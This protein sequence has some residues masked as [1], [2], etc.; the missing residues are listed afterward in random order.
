MFL[1]LIRF[2]KM[3][4]SVIDGEVNLVYGANNEITCK[5]EGPGKIIG[6]ESGNNKSHEDYQE[7]KR[8]VYHGKLLAYVQ[9]DKN[10]NSGNIKFKAESP[11]LESAALDIKNEK[12]YI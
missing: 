6:L 1:I 12:K 3:K 8:K 2:W 11:G 7:N 5:I 10:Q 4:V 9:S